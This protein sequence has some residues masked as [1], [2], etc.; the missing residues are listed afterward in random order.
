MHSGLL[1]VVLI[2]KHFTFSLLDPP[3]QNP[4]QDITESQCQCLYQTSRTALYIYCSQQPSMVS[5][6]Y[7][8]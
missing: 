5:C 3:V 1:L 6:S 2:R 4:Q 8:V 7:T